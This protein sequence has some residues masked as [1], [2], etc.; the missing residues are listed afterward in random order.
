VPPSVVRALW[1]ARKGA[2]DSS[3]DA[4][5]FPNTGYERVYRI[6]KAA[7]KAAGVPWV[8]L[9]TLRHTA[10]TLLFTLEGWNPKQVQVALGHHSAAF[11]LSVYVRLLSDD[12]PASTFFDSVVGDDFFGADDENAALNQHQVDRA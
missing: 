2:V 8:S 9:H 5:I 12:L 11:T 7:G 3:D 10:A 1:N 4:L 6:V